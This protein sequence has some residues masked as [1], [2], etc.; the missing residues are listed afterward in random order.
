MS[1]TIPQRVE[2]YNDTF[3]KWSASSLRVHGIEHPDP[4]EFVP[5]W[6]VEEQGREVL[7]GIWVIGAN[8]GN[9]TDYHWSYPRTYLERLQAVFPDLYTPARGPDVLHAFSG[10]LPESPFSRLDLHDEPY[11]PELVGNVYDVDQLTASR[12][13]LIMADPPYTDADAQVYRTEPLNRMKATSAL[14]RVADPGAF[15]VWLDT[16]WPQHS[17]EEWVTVGRIWVI[18]STNHVYRGATIFQR[19]G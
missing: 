7:Y 3:S 14:A 15:L 4:A 12:F 2:A 18:R 17:K 10:S 13:H 5:A 11:H 6:T 9:L 8:W 16:C 1:L 19:V